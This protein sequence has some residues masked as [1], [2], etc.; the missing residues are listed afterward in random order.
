[1]DPNCGLQLPFASQ[2]L[3]LTS[4]T[5]SSLLENPFRNVDAPESAISDAGPLSAGITSLRRSELWLN[6]RSK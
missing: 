6:V 3:H 4:L 5:V 1:M 2:T